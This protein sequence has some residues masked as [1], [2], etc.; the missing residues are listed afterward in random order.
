[1]HKE[2]SSYVVIEGTTRITAR[3]FY[4]TSLESVTLPTTLL[5]IGDRAFYACENLGVVIFNGYKAPLLEEEFKSE[6]VDYD[7]LPFTG[8]LRIYEGEDPIKGLGIVPFYMWNATSGWNN[9]YFGATFVD[10]IGHTKGNLVMV[11]PVNGENYDSFILSKYFGTVVNGHTAATEATL[12]VIAL[13]NALPK[14]IDLSHKAIVDKASTAYKNLSIDQQALI[15]DVNYDKL[16]SAMS[17]IKY[18]E[19][20][21]AIDPPVTD[22]PVDVTTQDV[23]SLVTIILL[24]VAVVGLGGYILVDKFVFKKKAMVENGNVEE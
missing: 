22:D 21:K 24:S 12:N 1:M 5:A 14:D 20:N 16:D 4:G 23:A 2:L 11:K 3:A 17:M 8:E 18:L 15:K 13:I 7:Q 10:R 9:F 19:D 6:Y